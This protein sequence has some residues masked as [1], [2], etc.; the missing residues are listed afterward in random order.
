MRLLHAVSF[1]M[2]LL[3][4]AQ[5]NVFSLKTYVE[6]ACRNSASKMFLKEILSYL[7]HDIVFHKL[8][9]HVPKQND[10]CNLQNNNNVYF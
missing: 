3:W 4:L 7:R 6:S 8:F 9:N 5:T 2:K 10:G 1:S